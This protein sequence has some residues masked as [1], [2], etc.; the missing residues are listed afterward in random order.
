[1]LM[2]AA[3]DVDA[4]AD[5]AVGAVGPGLASEQAEQLGLFEALQQYRFS[6]IREDERHFGQSG[7]QAR[8]Q[9]VDGAVDR[10][11]E[12]RPADPAWQADGEALGAPRPAEGMIGG[13]QP[14]SSPWSPTVAMAWRARSAPAMARSCR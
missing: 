14:D 6:V 5:G 10:A 8:R 7:T 13:M 3:P 2:C 11:P 9:C 12:A 1:M 4:R